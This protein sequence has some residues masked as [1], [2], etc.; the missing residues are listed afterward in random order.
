MDN[1]SQTSDVLHT[2][3]NV[4]DNIVDDNNDIE[5]RPVRRR[6][7]VEAGLDYW[8][9]ESD[10]K[11]DKEKR[12]AMKNRKVCHL[13]I[14]VL[15]CFFSRFEQSTDSVC[16]DTITK[17]LED[18]MPKEKL[19]EEVVAPYKQNWIGIFSVFIVVLSVIGNAFPELL[20]NPIIRIPDL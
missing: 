2:N 7:R 5:V 6:D 20:Q 11:K 18:T 8:I 3:S 1:I 4:F 10:L 19:R 16:C 13:F 9:D 14:Y 15:I 17:S 12:I